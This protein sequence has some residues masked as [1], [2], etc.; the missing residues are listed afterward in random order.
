MNKAELLSVDPPLLRDDRP[1]RTCPARREGSP[2]PST[3]G[4][5]SRATRRSRT[6]DRLITN[7]DQGET[8]RHQD[9]LSPRKT[10]DPD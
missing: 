2:V 9:E 5:I 1:S 3:A 4:S 7:S 6:G 8:P 10:E